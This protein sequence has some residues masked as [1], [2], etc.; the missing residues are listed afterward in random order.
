MTVY[1]LKRADGKYW[2][3][4]SSLSDEKICRARFLETEKDAKRL[5]NQLKNDVG[6][7]FTIIKIKID[8]F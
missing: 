5:V 1:A 3:G 7:L 2:I 4:C 8:E 6:I